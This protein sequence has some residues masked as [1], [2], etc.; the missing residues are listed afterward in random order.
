MTTFPAVTQQIKTQAVSQFRDCILRMTHLKA[1]YTTTQHKGC[2]YSKSSS[3]APNK[4]GL[5]FPFFAGYTTTT[6]RGLQNPKILCV[7]LLSPEKKKMA[8]KWHRFNNDNNDNITVGSNNRFT[9]PQSFFNQ[10]YTSCR[11]SRI[12]SSSRISR[13]KKKIKNCS[14]SNIFTFHSSFY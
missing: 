4:C 8:I 5:L 13:I 14:R 9:S 12:A 3:N 10:R 6:L 11:Q 1:N 7:L 2:L